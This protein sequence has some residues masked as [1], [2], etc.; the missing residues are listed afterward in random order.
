MDCLIARRQA[1]QSPDAD[2]HIATC[3]L[4]QAVLGNPGVDDTLRAASQALLQPTGP[5]DMWPSLQQALALDTGPRAW[6]RAL[7]RRWVVVVGWLVALGVIMLVHSHARGP[8]WDA[9]TSLHHAVVIVGGA[10]LLGVGLAL[11][12]RSIFSP[13][14]SSVLWVVGGMALLAAV[15]MAL[16]PG[17]VPAAGAPMQ[18][19]RVFF[20]QAGG[21]LNFGFFAT[22]PV[23]AW[24]MM[25]QRWQPRRPAQR[26]TAAA[27]AA[28]TGMI[29]LE[30]KCPAVGVMHRLVGHAS[31]VAALGIV[32]IVI[33]DPRR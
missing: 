6:L 7:P 5:Q 15:T 22:V 24:L 20:N 2:H 10:A 12:L 30:I 23:L 4:C 18:F 13:A 1:G 25:T 14:R 16:H 28:L 31:L 17:G 19:D 11:S 9:R 8:H 33:R 21:C 3:P 26:F 29:A 32:S 27:A